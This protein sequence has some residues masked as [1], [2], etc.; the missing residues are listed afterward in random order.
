MVTTRCTG[1]CGSLA[2]HTRAASPPMLWQTSMG[3]TPVKACARATPSEIS[4]A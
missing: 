1:V 4:F 2:S 3:G